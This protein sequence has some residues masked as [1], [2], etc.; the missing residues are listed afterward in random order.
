MKYAY[1][2]GCSQEGSA[3]DYGK[4]TGA[5]CAAL[6]IELAE[7]PGWSCCGSTPAHAVDTE[8]SAALCARN[9]DLAARDG[10][11][12]VVTPCPSCL[13]NLRL[14]AERM[15]EPVFRA[16]VNE[17][18]DAPV[19]GDLPESTSVMQLIGRVYD[20]DSLAARVTRPLT[21]LKIAAYYGCLMSRPADVMQF[22]DPENPTL[23]E[24]L[25]SACGAEMLEFPLKT[26]CCGAS[27][28]IPERPLTA[29]NSGRILDLATKLGADVIAVACPLCQMNLDLRQKQAARAEDA[30]FHM[31]V[32]YFTQLMGL[33]LGIAPEH[34]GLDQLCVSAGPLLRKME[35]ARA[36]AGVKGTEAKGGKA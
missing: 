16:R 22:G 3:L 33:A 11:G 9:L 24:S 30:F 23:M 17:L 12:Q 8:L 1:Y 27:F 34:L 10:A 6:G 31:P 7:I 21:G 14:A 29:R 35:A 28:G 25:L 32:L 5:L 36:A 20:A 19:A 13:S 15:K 4:S 26:V 2:P 18:L